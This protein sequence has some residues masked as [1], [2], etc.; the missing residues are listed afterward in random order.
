MSSGITT[1]D[2]LLPPRPFR[3]F[4]LRDWLEAMPHP[5]LVCEIASDRVAAAAWSGSRL[6][7]RGYA[8]EPL[9][10]GAVLA[11]AIET[12]I[13]AELA[14]AVR[15]A[16]ARVAERVATRGQAAALLVPDPVVRVFL[17]QFETFP[18]RQDEAV[19]LLRWRLK[20]SLPFDVDDA[21]VS[22]RRLPGDGTVMAAIAQRSVIRQYEEVAEAAGIVPGVVLS[23]SL[24]ALSLLDPAKVTLMVRLGGTS[25]TSVVA[26]LDTIRMYRCTELAGTAELVAA[27]ALADE[28]YP[29][30][31][32]MQEA[33]QQ[34][35]AEVR[36][37]GFGT[38][39]VEIARGLE[40]SLGLPVRPIGAPGAVIDGLSADGRSL[41]QQG[42]DSLVGW[43][44][45]GR[46]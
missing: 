34:P 45:S 32:F 35:V 16:F 20:K 17:L 43:M 24:A 31:A 7:A 10:A 19:P 42:L 11:S 29:A 26:H 18:S 41:L 44:G 30:I 6:S 15:A 33:H 27:S 9:P 5:G 4:G 25:L 2:T 38:Q 14:P 1:P 3:F 37:A 22:Y 23:A 39:A 8:V 40:S 28:V 13:T 46:E 12:N 21:V 36:L